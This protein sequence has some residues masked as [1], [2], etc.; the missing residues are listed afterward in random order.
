LGAVL[1]FASI[2]ALGAGVFVNVFNVFIA[3]LPHGAE[4][5]HAVRW[6]LPVLLV[7]ILVLVLTLFYRLVPNTHVFW[8][9]ALAGR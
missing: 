2:T 8:R 3:R 5:I 4:L 6:A 7:V 9:A 1:F